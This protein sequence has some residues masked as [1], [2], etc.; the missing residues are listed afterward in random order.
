MPGS[1]PLSAEARFLL[2]FLGL[3]AV[4]YLLLAIPWVD[5]HV[6][7]PVF[8]LSA[9]M[10]AWL[11]NCA[12]A[13]AVVEGVIV[14]GPIHA[15]A[16]RRGCDPLDPIALF[17]AGVLAFPAGARA[18]AVGLLVGAALLF[19][20]N[21]LRLGSLYWLGPAGLLMLALGL[22]LTWLHWLRKRQLAVPKGHA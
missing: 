6:L 13:E 18:R 21:V 15:I 17:S 4:Y 7:L 1:R 12:G 9:K 10:T 11:V 22:W 3:L 2:R 19:G 5:A 16:V 14:R 20:V 8:Q